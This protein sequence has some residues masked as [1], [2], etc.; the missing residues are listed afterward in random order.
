MT[1]TASSSE[2]LLASVR[3]LVEHGR[4]LWY[5]QG[6]VR[7]AQLLLRSGRPQ[8]LALEISRD[9]WINNAVT[10]IGGVG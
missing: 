1:L 8:T 9:V 2:R 3:V 10:V 5:R 6:K 7:V 4:E